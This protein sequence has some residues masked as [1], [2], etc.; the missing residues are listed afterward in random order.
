MREFVADDEIELRT[1]QVFAE[2]IRQRDAPPQAE[3][4]CQ[5]PLPG[6]TT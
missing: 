2:V 1:A 3:G 4:I 6:G 5:M